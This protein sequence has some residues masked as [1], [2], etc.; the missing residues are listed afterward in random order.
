[1]KYRQ[2]GSIPHVIIILDRDGNEYS[3]APPH[4]TEQG[5][6]RIAKPEAQAIAF[7]SPDKIKIKAKNV[8]PESEI[9]PD[10]LEVLSEMK[11]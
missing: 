9:P 11:L 2:G 7:C 6:Q 4:D 3:Y 10:I 5:G 8:R 1:L